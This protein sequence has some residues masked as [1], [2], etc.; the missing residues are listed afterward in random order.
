MNSR[1]FTAA[2]LVSAA[3]LSSWAVSSASDQPHSSAAA[4]VQ[5]SPAALPDLALELDA[6][7][8]RLST[9][10]PLA[11]TPATPGR[12]PFRFGARRGMSEFP[13]ASAGSVTRAMAVSEFSSPS[14]SSEPRRADLSDP[15][16]S[17]EAVA[18]PEAANQPRLSGIAEI[19]AGSLTAVINFAGELHYARKG[20][21]IAGRYRIDA[22]AFDGADVF[23]LVLGTISRLKLQ[24]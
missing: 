18:F 20:D 4:A 14:V 8:A 11:A 10:M 19:S 6:E 15:G 12:D 3:L 23:D 22:I 13:S 21:V 16:S 9:R 2:W 1:I 7:I 24:A 5:P 17:R